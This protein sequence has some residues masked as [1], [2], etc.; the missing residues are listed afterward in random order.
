[1]IRILLIDDQDLIRRGLRALLKSDMELQIVGEG[2]NGNEAIALVESLQPDVVLMDVRMPEMDGVAAT[3]QISQSFPNVKVLILTTFDD[4][5]YITAALRFGAAGYLLKDTPFE[6]LTQAIRLVQKGYT[7]LAPGLASKILTTA[8]P[9][10]PPA[11]FA[12]LTPREQ[13]ILHLIAKGANNQEIADAL[14]ISEKTVRNNI[15]NILGEL[16]LRDRTQAAIW[17]HSVVKP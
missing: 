12:N 16:G 11:N 5:D 3:Q 14:F 1:M 4:R 8:T 17:M 6:E 15:T 7:Q 10:N 2:K 13:E 9:T